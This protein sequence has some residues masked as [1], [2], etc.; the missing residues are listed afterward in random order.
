[1]FSSF[2]KGIW[3]I[4][5]ALA[6]LV[7][8][9]VGAFIMMILGLLA[10]FALVYHSGIREGKAEDQG[11]KVRYEKQALDMKSLQTSYTELVSTA[12]ADKY[13]ADKNYS[14]YI[15]A[16]G[17]RKKE[18]SR[19]IKAERL[20]K[21]FAGERDEARRSAKANLILANATKDTLQDTRT[22]LTSTEMNLANFKRLAIDLTT[23]RNKLSEQLFASNQIAEQVV[24]I[25]RINRQSKLFF[26]LSLL[27]CFGSVMAPW[28]KARRAAGL[29]Y[30]QALSS[31]RRPTV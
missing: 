20:G 15:N 21:R 24:N 29:P 2:I 22:I 25:E 3:S 31:L 7:Y 10:I 5:N 4:S 9:V 27:I 6:S 17:Q 1:M 8:K 13:R 23:Q 14:N 19:A 26:S 16:D 30:F 18:K 12:E 11:W 28:V